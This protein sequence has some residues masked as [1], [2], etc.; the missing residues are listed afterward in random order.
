MNMNIYKRS[1]I[2]YTNMLICLYEAQIKKA[3]GERTE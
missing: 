1:Q 2:D 3:L